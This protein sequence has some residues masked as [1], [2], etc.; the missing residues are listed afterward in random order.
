[1][2]WRK[3]LDVIEVQDRSAAR[4]FSPSRFPSP[5]RRLAGGRLEKEWEI[6]P[7]STLK[8]HIDVF[9]A[10]GKARTG[11][12]V[13]NN[14]IRWRDP[15]GLAPGDW[16]DPGT[17]FNSGFTSS[18]ADTAESIS[19]GAGNLLAGDLGGAAQAAAN[20]PLVQTECNPVANN[21]V[22]GSLAVSAAAASL[23]GGAG[24][25]EALAEAGGIPFTPT[26][27]EGI[28]QAENTPGIEGGQALLNTLAQ[29]LSDQGYSPE[30]IID[31]LGPLQGGGGF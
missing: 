17:W 29:T 18:W 15:F 28:Q 21:L 30:E 4:R 12:F 31:L 7:W 23:T 10:D 13:A 2:A 5:A 6:I 22:L 16:W 20:N 19:E 27:I 14:P 1:M 26:Q 3:V 11:L 8:P 9:E 25:I 24:I